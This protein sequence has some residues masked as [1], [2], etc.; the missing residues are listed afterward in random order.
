MHERKLYLIATLIPS[1]NEE[2]INDA[3][4]IMEKRG[5]SMSPIACANTTISEG[6]YKETGTLVE[7]VGGVGDINEFADTLVTEF[8]SNGVAS[9]NDNTLLVVRPVKHLSEHIATELPTLFKEGLAYRYSA[10]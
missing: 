5:I 1:G 2:K 7:G 4:T 10:N 6:E 3:V 9:E 8:T